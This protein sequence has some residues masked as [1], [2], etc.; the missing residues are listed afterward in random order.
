MKRSFLLLL[1]AFAII[2]ITKS[3]DIDPEYK[4]V[5]TQRSEKIA[6]TLNITDSEKK[7]RVIQAIID[8]Y[9]KVGL[10]NDSAENQSK[11]AKQITNKEEK[12]AKL[13]LI[14]LE[15]NA[16]LYDQHCAFMGNLAIDLSNDQIEAVKDGLTYG[17]VKV[18]YDSYLDM[19]PTLKECEK[20][21][22]YAWLVE[23]REHAIGASS[24]KDKHGWFGKYKGR[25]NNYLSKQGYD[26]QAERKAWEE[27]LKAA[28]KTL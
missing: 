12:E 16:K 13:K 26:S 14:E 23:A 20:R 18:T 28:G 15:K 8:Q 1:F 4:K 6:N 22:I 10:I 7:E 11:A 27:R 2:C 21:Q 3:Q 5:L 17:V 9:H 24:S 25:I 19:I